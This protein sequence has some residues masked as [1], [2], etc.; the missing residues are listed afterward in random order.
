MG[1]YPNLY[2]KLTCE[3]IVNHRKYTYTKNYTLIFAKRYDRMIL[4]DD[5]IDRINVKFNDRYFQRNNRCFK[6]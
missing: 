4:V 2:L 5:S 1:I 3:I 6:I